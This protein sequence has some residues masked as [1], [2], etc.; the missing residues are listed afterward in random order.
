MDAG[1]NRFG[2]EGGTPKTTFNSEYRVTDQ[3]PRDSYR[4]M[5]EHLYVDMAQ[6][7][8][9]EGVL[10]RTE[11]KEKL[12]EMKAAVGSM[13]V[14]GAFLLVGVFAV[15]ATAIIAL[16]IVLPLWASA[17]IVTAALLLV[18]G[19]MVAGAKKKLNAD[20]LTPHQSLD[21]LGE[22]KTTFKE[23]FNEFKSTHH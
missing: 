5:A 6:L 20:Q 21:T 1:E 11:V 2:T 19:V 13:V 8:Q 22:I 17:L 10:I 18:G 3:G 12:D 4:A 14:G 15:V 23:R 9:R 7:F 16:D